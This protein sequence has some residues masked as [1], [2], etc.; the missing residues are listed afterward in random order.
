MLRLYLPILI[1]QN[2]FL[3]RCNKTPLNL[4]VLTSVIC[5]VICNQGEGLGRRES[6]RI[7]SKA[8]IVYQ[9]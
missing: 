8:S 5:Y 2:D 4:A 1:S 3:D 6:A 9:Q 7:I